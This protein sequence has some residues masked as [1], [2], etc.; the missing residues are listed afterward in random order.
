MISVTRADMNHCGK[1]PDAPRELNT[2]MR[3]GRMESRHHIM[4]LKVIGLMSHDLAAELRMH[5]ST[6]D[7]GTSSNEKKLQ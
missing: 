6:V 1:M 5:S 3:D 7:Y 4:S 2:S